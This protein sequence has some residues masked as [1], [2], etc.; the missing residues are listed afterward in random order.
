[1]SIFVT[2]HKYKADQIANKFIYDKPLVVEAVRSYCQYILKYDYLVVNKMYT[3]DKFKIEKEI[4]LLLWVIKLPGEAAIIYQRLHMVD[5]VEECL[6]QMIFDYSGDK[7]S[8]K[9]LEFAKF[10]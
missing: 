1:V 8:A 4:A 2:I 6:N 10:F 5:K 9:I 3:F 7:I